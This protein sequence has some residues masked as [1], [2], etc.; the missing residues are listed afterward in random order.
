MITCLCIVM[1]QD[2]K[3]AKTPTW[4]KLTAWKTYRDAQVPPYSKTTNRVEG[5]SVIDCCPFTRGGLST[6]YLA[7]VGVS[8]SGYTLCPTVGF[9]LKSLRS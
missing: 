8:L 5:R 9:W 4:L 6:A 3:D 1:F 2:P 7:V